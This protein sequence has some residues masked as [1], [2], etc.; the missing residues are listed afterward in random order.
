[1]NSQDEPV[2]LF[3]LL[4]VFDPVPSLKFRVPSDAIDQDEDESNLEKIK[5]NTFVKKEKKSSG[6]V[7][8][9][10]VSLT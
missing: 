10:R 8:T 4:D 9:E 2:Q 7:N 3:A 5:S 6:R 1:M